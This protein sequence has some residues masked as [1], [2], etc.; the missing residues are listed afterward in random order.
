[1]ESGR[2]DVELA[3]RIADHEGVDAATLDPPLH[4]VVDV[5]ALEALLSPHSHERTDFTGTVSFEY[6]ECT[7]TVDHTGAVSVR[8]TLE[9]AE[10]ELATM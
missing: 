2:L 4:D 6:G 5:D 3:Q 7:I 1:M 8:P 10:A 9:D